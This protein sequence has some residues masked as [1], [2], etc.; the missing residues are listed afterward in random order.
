VPSPERI[1][2]EEPSPIE[3]GLA[4]NWQQF[5]LLVLVN[6][7]VGAMV[8]LERT[9][10]PL[11][12][13]HDFGLASRTAILSFLVTFGLTKA[14]ANL[15]AGRWSDRVGRKPILVMGWICG[16]PVPFLLMYA[17]SWD[18]VVFANVLLGINQGL[19]WSTTVIM[20]IDL[21]GPRQRGLAMGLN[22]FAGYLA[23]ALSAWFTGYLAASYGLRPVPFYSGVAFSGLGLLL[24]LFA[25]SETR[26]HAEHEGRRQDPS[27]SQAAISFRQIFLL[28]SWK[29]RSL[30]ATSQ[31]GLVNNLNDGMMWGLLPL[32][33]TGAGLPLEKLGMIVAVY[34]GVW[35]L[36]QLITGALSDRWGRKWMIASGMWIQGVAIAMVVIFH[37]FGP[38]I[39]SSILLGVG[40]ALVYPT[41]LASISDLAEPAWR[42]S[43][44]GVYRLW[45]DFGY[46]VGGLAAGLIADALGISAAIVAVSAL[47]FLSGVVAAGVMTETL[48]PAS[49]E[50]MSRPSGATNNIRI[51]PEP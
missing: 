47:T 44:V 18:W 31:A 24:S 19:C 48:C 35:G 28:T 6:A 17:S 8:G 29:N 49:S 39:A 13:E 15:L 25:I 43:A 34:P 42:A 38:W 2:S 11:I 27:K 51:Y 50:R 36:S 26:S 20:K 37:G 23:V 32:F 5:S 33:L 7:F 41:L 3:L 21:V 9:L 45:R 10:L 14:I 4:S 16:L 30:F 46:A 1:S 12:A 22:E 40:T